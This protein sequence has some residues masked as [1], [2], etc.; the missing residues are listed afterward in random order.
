LNREF[1][2]SY[3]NMFPVLSAFCWYLT[4]VSVRGLL[5]PTKAVTDTHTDRH[6]Q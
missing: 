4:L 5:A 2:G 1:L 6:T 3:V